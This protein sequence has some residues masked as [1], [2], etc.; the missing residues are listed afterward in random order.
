MCQ[1]RMNKCDII[2][3]NQVPPL[4]NQE[5]KKSN[6]STTHI[7]FKV[8]QVKLIGFEEKLGAVHSACVQNDVCALRDPVAFYDV[9]RQGSTH[10]EV[11]H[12]VE[13]QAFVDE[14]LHHLQLVKILVLKLSLTCSSN[15]LL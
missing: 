12:W 6:E 1:T 14:A 11:H 15:R 2:F 10:G 5:K 3:F 4:S 13:A 7:V 8:F 9:I